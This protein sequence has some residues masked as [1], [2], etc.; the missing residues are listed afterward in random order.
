[1]VHL[2]SKGRW[3]DE[4]QD[5]VTAA[6]AGNYSNP[7]DVT[8]GIKNGYDKPLY[9][10]LALEGPCALDN[11]TRPRDESHGMRA[12]Q[13]AT[14]TS[15]ISIILA[16]CSSNAATRRAPGRAVCLGSGCAREKALDSG[17]RQKL[18]GGQTQAVTRYLL[19]LLV[20]KPVG[21]EIHC[22]Q[23]PRAVNN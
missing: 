1:M 13:T 5:D 22:G 4:A 19:A 10:V 23:V 12:A 15:R 7:T 8:S 9:P 14:R 21:A 6:I 18:A 11:S 17:A 2:K 16:R 20:G 3:A